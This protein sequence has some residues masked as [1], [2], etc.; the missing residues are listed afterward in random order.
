MIRR[1]YPWII[2]IA[3]MSLL[4]FSTTLV[5]KRIDWLLW[6]IRFGL[7]A[8]LSL[9]VLWSRW[10]HRNDR[11]TAKD[12]AHKDSADRFIHHPG[13]SGPFGALMDEYAR[14]AEDFCRVVESFD[15]AGFDA[16]RPSNN[17][18]TISPRAICLHVIGA[19]HRYAH[20]IRKA[21]GVDFVERYEADP[22]RLHSPGCPRFVNRRNRVGGADRRAAAEGN[23][24]RNSGAVVR[25][26]L[27]SAIRPGDDPRARG[28]PLA[29]ASSATGALVVI[30]GREMIIAEVRISPTFR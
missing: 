10:R 23:R 15:L 29:A 14:A 12:A 2:F 13:L 6:P 17:P 27:G 1:V 28:L 24:G 5:A 21:R 30:Y 3:Y 22:A 20:Y 7:I 8:G 9:F 26:A 19:A 4:V 11:P 18:N 25:G 16:E